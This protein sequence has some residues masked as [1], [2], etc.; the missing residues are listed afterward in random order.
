V[1]KAHQLSVL[2]K[3]IERQ[4]GQPTEGGQILPPP[5]GVVT[6]NVGTEIPPHCF[7]E[8][9]NADYAGNSVRRRW[10]SS[11]VNLE[12][13]IHDQTADIHPVDFRPGSPFRAWY[14][15]AGCPGESLGTGFFLGHFDPEQFPNLQRAIYYAGA[16]TG[17]AIAPYGGQ[18]ML[19]LDTELRQ[20]NLLPVPWG[21]ENIAVSG[22]GQDVVL[23]QLSLAP[24]SA[25]TIEAMIEFDGYL[26]I[27]CRTAGG[28]AVFTWDGKT[29]REDETGAGIPTGLGLYRDQLIMGFTAASNK[30]MVRERGASPGTWATVTPGAGTVACVKGLNSIRSYRDNA[31]IVDGTGGNIWKYNGSTVAIDRTPGADTITALAVGFG[32][33]YYGYV[34][35][36]DGFAKIGQLSGTTYT[37]VVKDMED[38]VSGANDIPAMEFYRNSII[39]VLRK[40][41]QTAFVVSENDDLAS[42]DWETHSN[43]GIFSNT[44]YYLVPM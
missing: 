39:A 31:Y 6:E 3:D 21:T 15:G 23:A 41:A 44:V 12:E 35:T 18:P 2:T 28:F 32:K 34:K 29:I 33:L 22:A 27:A 4:Y 25:T 43:V 14:A 11:N 10:G 24:W 40:T 20:L 37:D 8:L 5:G 16:A 30:I 42:G 17:I 38:V 26:F 7:T 9:V 1:N 19:G 36:S 13:Y